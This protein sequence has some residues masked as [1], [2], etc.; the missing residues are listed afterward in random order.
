MKK[1]TKSTLWNYL[2]L[3]LLFCIAMPAYANNIP[4]NLSNWL[5]GVSTKNGQ[6]NATFAIS[7]LTEDEENFGSIFKKE[8]KL[9]VVGDIRVASEHVGKAGAVYVVAKYNNAWYMKTS[10]GWT[11]WNLKVSGLLPVS[12]SHELLEVESPI[13]ESELSNLLGGFEVFLGYKVDDDLN[14]TNTP[15]KFSVSKPESA[16][17]LAIKSFSVESTTL[18]VS[19]KAKLR[20]TIKNLGS[21]QAADTQLSYYQ[22]VNKS[23]EENSLNTGDQQI[24]TQSLYRLPTGHSNDKYCEV[25]MPSEAGDY[26][27]GVCVKTVEGET[28]L[29]NNCSSAIKITVTESEEVVTT[30]LI[31]Q[32]DLDVTGF[33][34]TTKVM[35][36]GSFT[37]IATGGANSSSAAIIY[38][39]NDIGVATVDSSSGLVVLIGAGTA[40]I[41][42][43]K[44]ADNTYLAAT[45]SYELI[46]TA[47]ALIP[48]AALGHNEVTKE[49]GSGDIV[50]MVSGGTGGGARTYVSSD[51]TV[52]IVDGA[53]LVTMKSLGITSI[54]VTQASDGIYSEASVS[55]DVTV[56][57]D[58][59]AGVGFI[60]TKLKAD[61]SNLSDQNVDWVS[62]GT[63]A[64]NNQWSCVRDFNTNLIWEVKTDANKSLK[65]GW[66]GIT[67][68]G[69]GAVTLFGIYLNDWDTLVNA[70]NAGLGL[71]NLTSWRVPTKS[72]LA[73]ITQKGVSSGSAIDMHYFPNTLGER[74]WTASPVANDHLRAWAIGFGSGIDNAAERATTEHVRLVH[75]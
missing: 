53:G 28:N 11:T 47:A 51:D 14:Y 36:S 9:R 57:P 24:C 16:P 10:S 64:N 66:G 56:E 38:S 5:T 58:S 61:G 63:E 30:T 73:S 22:R 17:D 7:V 18:E 25:D 49:I 34:D 39:S 27:Y 74:Y 3:A 2:R 40:T 67:A 70:A 62:G 72:E 1:Q 65:Y 42:A 33:V 26:Y 12:P 69:K 15:L 46:V 55:F 23:N 29:T 43:T 32:D 4:E 35:G 6:S 37:Q 54:T 31:A 68:I 13:I 45:A 71:C 52:A 48:Q 21:A 44:P 75:D 41:T 8:Q 59:I 19:E 20:V 50:L 60:Y